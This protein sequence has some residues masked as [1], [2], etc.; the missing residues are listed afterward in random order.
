MDNFTAQGVQAAEAKMDALRGAIRNK[1]ET[2]IQFTSGDIN[3]LIAH[4]PAFRGMRGHAHVTIDNSLIV[5]EVSTPLNFT[6]WERL[7]ERWF[8]GNVQFGLSYVDEE[9]NFDLKSAETNSRSL[10][11]I[12]FNADFLRAFNRSLNQ[13]FHRESRQH[14]D[15][16]WH[17]L[18]MISVQNGQ[19][20]V[21]TRGT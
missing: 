11:S 5:L 1:V 17:R 19:L 20:I 9:L 16:V 2:T 15:D 14:A 8:N 7:K 10:P 12:L 13:S 4:D 21:T 3:A 6:S 18:K